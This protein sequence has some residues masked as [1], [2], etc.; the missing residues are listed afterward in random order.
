MPSQNTRTTRT[1]EKTGRNLFG[2]LVTPIVVLVMVL[3]VAAFV[4]LRTEETDENGAPEA[5]RA[6]A[7]ELAPVA[8]VDLQETVRG[9]GTLDPVRQVVIKPEVHGKLV[10]VHFEEGGFVEEGQVLFK[11]EDEK[12]ARQYEARRAALQ[13][14]RTRIG[15]LRRNYERIASLR[16]R[17][18]V[19]ED[20]Y[21]NAKTEL[22][23]VES[24]AERLAS[25]LALAAR[26]LEDA[27]IASPFDG[28]I[29][30]Q[31]VDPGTFVGIGD[32]LAVLYAIDPVRISFS[33]AEKYA[34]RIKR[35]QDVIAEVSAYP[36]RRFRGEVGFISPVVEEGTRKFLIRADIDN[37]DN[38]LMP[39]TFASAEVVLDTRRD[40][41]VIP[42]QALLPTR[43]G[44]IVYVVDAGNENARRR[45]VKTGL[46]EPGLVEITRGLST[47]ELVVVYGH[48]QLDDGSP[49]NI[50]NRWNP[51][52]PEKN[53]SGRRTSAAGMTVPV[54]ND[55][56][57]VQ[58]G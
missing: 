34:G 9:V 20:Q 41:P 6:I 29:S 30:R 56:P 35:G 58:G 38:I 50:I 49:V 18:L 4:Y 54:L 16:E 37:P 32:P 13:S 26:E 43:E 8:A 15:N 40:A 14:T 17:D 51:G 27:I 11:I 23:A 5:R 24:D 53:D 55:P 39:G 45:E 7:V 57:T 36:N 21:H 12:L 10:S 3:I 19:S 22:E 2:R 52:W 44:Y 1:P 28:Y 48:M 47:E 31:M 25:E 33:I 46:R 42:E